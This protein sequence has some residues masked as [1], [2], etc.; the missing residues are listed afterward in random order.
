MPNFH[1]SFRRLQ[2]FEHLSSLTDSEALAVVSTT[3]FVVRAF[4]AIGLIS[5]LDGSFNRPTS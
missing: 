3:S 4:L 2:K 1:R 5:D